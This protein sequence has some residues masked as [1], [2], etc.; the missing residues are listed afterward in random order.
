MRLR[1]ELGVKGRTLHINYKSKL[2]GLIY[3]ML[4]RNDRTTALHDVGY[5]IQNRPFKL[6]VFSDFIGRF[7]LDMQVMIDLVDFLQH[8]Y[9]VSLNQEILDVIDFEILYEPL[10]RKGAPMTFSTISPV[11][12]YRTDGKKIHYLSPDN[13]LFIEKIN[14]NILKKCQLVG[15]NPPTN[16]PIIQINTF[17]K[18]SVYFRKTFFIAYN[19]EN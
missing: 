10:N 13:D 17:K 3:Y 19:H 8:H 5:R 16:T 4:K 9:Q 11:T 15:I 7:S 18:R 14:D 1:I 12:I 6:F 2:Q